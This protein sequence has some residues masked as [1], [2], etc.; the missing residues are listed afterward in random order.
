MTA[1]TWPARACATCGETIDVRSDIPGPWHCEEHDESEEAMVTEKKLK[2]MPRAS[3]RWA[4][5]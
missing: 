2:K 3:P 4:S 5:T 1:P